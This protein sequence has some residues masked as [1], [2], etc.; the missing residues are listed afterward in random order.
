[1]VVASSGPRD[2]SRILKKPLGTFSAGGQVFSI[3]FKGTFTPNGDGSFSA[4]IN[5]L[6]PFQ[7]TVHYT[8]YPSPDGNTVAFVQTDLGNT[9]NGV[10]TRH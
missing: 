8:F 7:V 10:L 5:I 1:V 6:T 9:E 3:T 4:I 2:I